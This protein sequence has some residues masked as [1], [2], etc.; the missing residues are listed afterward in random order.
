M[1]RSQST[2]GCAATTRGPPPLLLERRK[3]REEASR[4]LINLRDVVG[5]AK[6]KVSIEEEAALKL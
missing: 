2:N 1:E 4:I 5:S 3:S 6:A